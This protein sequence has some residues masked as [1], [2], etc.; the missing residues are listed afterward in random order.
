MS[1]TFIKKTT[2]VGALSSVVLLS[3]CSI[4]FMAEKPAIPVDV[5]KTESAQ[6]PEKLFFDFA[7]ESG[8]SGLEKIG[9]TD[10]DKE[11]LMKSESDV[12]IAGDFNMEGTPIGGGTGTFEMN[13][14][15][16]ADY[17]DVKNP[18]LSE[19]V[20][21]K[22]DAL[23][24][25]FKLDT[26]GEIRIVDTSVFAQI[27]KFDANFPGL[28]PEV[29]AIIEKFSGQWYGNSFVELNTMVENN[30]GLKGF[31]TQ[32]FLTG[33]ISPILDAIALIQDIGNNPKN[34]ITFGKF[35]EEK[36]GYYFFEVTPKKETYEKFA[37]IVIKLLANTGTEADK[38]VTNVI[39][40]ALEKLSV[41]S[42]IIGYTPEHP[43]YF[44][45]S[46][47]IE[48]DG[49]NVLVENT[50]K[51]ITISIAKTEGDDAGEVVFTKTS[52]GK[53]SLIVDIP[54]EYNGERTEVLSGTC[55]DTKHEFTL[56]VPL[57][58]S[59]LGESALK[60]VLKGTF[61]KTGDTWAGELTSPEFEKGK[62]VI[63]DVK[64]GVYNAHAKISAIY[65]ENTVTNIV[66]D[67]KSK[68]PETVT[69][70][71]P[72]NVKSFETIPSDIEKEMNALYN[73]TETAKDTKAT[74]KVEVTTDDSSVMI[75]N[76][77]VE[78]KNGDTEVKIDTDGVVIDADAQGGA[79]YSEISGKL[80]RMAELMNENPT[81]DAEAEFLAI[82][83][84]VDA[85]AAENDIPN[86]TLKELLLKE[87]VKQ[88]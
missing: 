64:G 29:K 69:L 62:L 54:T 87:I 66:F 44:T 3:G 53:F 10:F 40:S 74:E 55:T 61:K 67:V 77:N 4:P 16:K 6:N 41:Q 51:G 11:L 46:K 33:G 9:L 56:S 83:A 68:K 88:K 30:M 48:E 37:N 35:V 80:A 34:H 82:K 13:I 81:G 38:E 59:E 25:L 28:T 58:D 49:T 57:Y 50:E 76:G 14:D 79:D 47:V 22:V 17:S 52:E 32:K 5:A 27:A 15:A 23:G 63:S 45:I 8:K 71:T 1:I 85:Y 26:S 43:E 31:D 42:V 24:G 65:G 2:A 84:E 73:T 12:S 86:E 36:D 7:K 70:E 19:A 75:N 18:L 39:T 20:S 78:V 60:E 72:E 21:V